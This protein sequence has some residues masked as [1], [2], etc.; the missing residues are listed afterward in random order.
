[1]KIFLASIVSIIFTTSAFGCEIY[2]HANKRIC[3][4]SCAINKYD[5]EICYSKYNMSYQMG[6]L[7]GQRHAFYEV[8]ALINDLYPN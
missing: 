8:K 1:M 2:D 7:Q 3:D 6:Y 4:L 5:E